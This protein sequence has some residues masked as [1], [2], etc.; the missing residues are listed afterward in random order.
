MI[1]HPGQKLSKVQEADNYSV[2]PNN[3]KLNVSGKCLLLGH[4]DKEISPINAGVSPDSPVI[5]VSNC[6][7]VSPGIIV[8]PVLS[9]LKNMAMEM[10]LSKPFPQHSLGLF[11]FLEISA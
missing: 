6:F 11:E 1:L 2:S 10:G 4:N 8:D 3:A 9:S 7:V 5:D